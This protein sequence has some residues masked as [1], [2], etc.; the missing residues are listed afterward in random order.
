[1]PSTLSPHRRPAIAAAFVMLAAMACSEGGRLVQPDPGTLA[2]PSIPLGVVQ[3]LECSGSRASPALSCSPPATPNGVRG[4]VSL[5]ATLVKL[6]SSNPAYNS[7]TGHFTFNVT[8]QNLKIP[9]TLATTNGTTLDPSGLRAFFATGPTVTSGSGTITV[10][11]DGVG[12]FTATNQPYYQYNQMLATGVVSAPRTWTLVMPATVNTFSFTLYVWT[13]V[14]YPNGYVRLDGQ[15]PGGTFSGP[16]HPGNTHA[17]AAV[18][19][20][21]SGE[22]APVSRIFFNSSNPACARVDSLGVVTGVMTTASDTLCTITADDQAFRS[23]RMIF[24]VK[25]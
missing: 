22:N 25:P 12:M 2:G 24:K 18:S 7:G 6:T 20:K 9:Q 13:Q 3:T 8:V 1:M 5:G 4:S 19:V 21:A 16:F 15:L 17:L 11:G 10:L 23:G 14:Q